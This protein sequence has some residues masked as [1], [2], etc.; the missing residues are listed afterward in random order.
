MDETYF[1][2]LVDLL[3]DDYLRNNY[4]KLFEKLYST[5]FVWKIPFDENRAKDGLR[6]RE[7]FAEEIGEKWQ[8]TGKNGYFGAIFDDFRPCSVLEMLVALAQ[9]GADDILWEPDSEDKTGQLFWE[10]IENL[11]LD[12]YD[13]FHWFEK[14]VEH[15]LYDFLERKYG[16]NGDGNAFVLRTADPRK[17]DLWL[18]LNRYVI[19]SRK[20]GQN[21]QKSG[22]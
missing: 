15:I 3:G 14:E 12:I 7:T 11:G 13:D 8:K 21:L 17:M 9:R 4:R 5:E 19:E 2:W 1:R 10:M 6:L 22:A 20:S 18:Q 16:S